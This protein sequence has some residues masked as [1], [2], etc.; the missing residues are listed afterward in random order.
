M[1][2]LGWIT[3]NFTARPESRA[4]RRSRDAEKAGQQG[5]YYYVF[6]LARTLAEYERLTEEAPR[7]EGQ[8]RHRYTTGGPSSRDAILERRRDDGWWVNDGRG[9]VGR[10][11]ARPRHELRDAGP[12]GAERALP[13]AP[14]SARRERPDNRA[15][16]TGGTGAEAARRAALATAA[17][18]VLDGGRTVGRDG[19]D[20]WFG[21]G[22]RCRHVPSSPARPRRRRPPSV[23]SG[24][25]RCVRCRARARARRSSP[26]RVLRFSGRSPASAGAVALLY[27]AVAT[28]AAGL[29]RPARR[30]PRC[31]SMPGGRPSRPL[32]LW[33]AMAGLFWADP[34]AER[35]AAHGAPRVSAGRA[36]RR[37]GA[38]PGLRRRRASIGSA[39]PRSTS[40][41]RWPPRSSS[42]R[43]PS[44]T[45][46]LWLVVGLV[47]AG[48]GKWGRRR[49]TAG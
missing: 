42:V 34:V 46:A 9:A 43:V 36:P 27:L 23:P 3:E 38:R 48:G 26:A 17:R 18:D 13:V 47:A 40:T 5:W 11:R 24:R 15:G 39:P 49:S 22:D 1:A 4:S 35:L 12:G 37:S 32:V 25:R 8:P 45:G 10:G 30:R 6:T 41:C 2:A 16:G 20:A 31:P 28:A 29:V 7:R 19:R 14:M 33:T 21:A 44:S